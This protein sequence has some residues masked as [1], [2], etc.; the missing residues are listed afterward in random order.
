MNLDLA[1][2]R[3]TLQ[4]ARGQSDLPE[5]IQWSTKVL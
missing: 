1:P 5:A 3:E 2:G 4:K